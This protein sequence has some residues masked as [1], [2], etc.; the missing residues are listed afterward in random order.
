M[1]HDQDRGQQQHQARRVCAPNSGGVTAT[2]DVEIGSKG[3]AKN[4]KVSSAEKQAFR[5]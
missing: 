1:R 4:Q 2:T 5:H 3:T